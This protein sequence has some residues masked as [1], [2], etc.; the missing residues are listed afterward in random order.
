MPKI[1]D[2]RIIAGKRNRNNE[3]R[4]YFAKRW[5]DGMR[6]EVIYDEVINKWGIGESSIDRILKTDD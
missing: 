2:K 1:K 5:K 3:I 4:A 6:T